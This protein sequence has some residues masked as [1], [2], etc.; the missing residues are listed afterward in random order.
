MQIEVAKIEK[1]L[2]KNQL[3]D[4]KLSI[5]GDLD[6]IIIKKNPTPIVG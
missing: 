2:S 4:L 6:R 3:K 5:E 1:I